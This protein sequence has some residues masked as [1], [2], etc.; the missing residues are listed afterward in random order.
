MAAVAAHGDEAALAA[1]G[2]IGSP[3]DSVAEEAALI[4]V[5]TV[6][7]G[8]GETDCI[9]VRQG[10]DP[11]ELARAF[12]AKHTL[13]EGI[14]E[15]LA[16][17][18]CDNLEEAAE[19]ARNSA[20]GADQGGEAYLDDV[21]DSEYGSHFDGRSMART[22]SEDSAVFE[23]LYQQAVSLK[24]K[25]QATK[26]RYEVEREL[27]VTSTKQPMSWVSHE[28]MRERTSG[29]Y[30]NYGEMLYA[31]S[32]ESSLLRRQ[33]AE[34]QRAERYAAE[35]ASATFTPEITRMA[36]QMRARTDAAGVPAWQRLSQAATAKTAERHAALRRER[37]QAEARECTFR[38]AI[39][40]RS[41]RLMA[42]RSETLKALNVSAHH[43]LYQDSLRRQAKQESYANWYPEDA[44]FQPKLVATLKRSKSGGASS[45]QQMV[46]RL[47]SS[48]EK[49]QNKLTEA[50]AK[51]HGSIDPATGRT[52]FKPKTGRGP[53]F[54]RRAPEQPVG[55]YLF[56][57]QHERDEKARARLEDEARRAVED[58][59]RLKT[60]ASSAAIVRRLTRKRFQQIFD[61]LD[62]AS[63]GAIDLAAVLE[64]APDT[65]AELDDDVRDDVENAARL[66]ER[67]VI[68][69]RPREPLGATARSTP[70]PSPRQLLVDA[71]Q[72]DFAAFCALMDEAIAQHPR[73]RPYLARCCA[74]KLP[75]PD[76]FQPRIDERS[77]ALAA[78]LRP[79]DTP[80]HEVLYREATTFAT[81]KAALKAAA[82]DETMR[83]CTFAPRLVAEQL[84]PTGR[85]MREVRE[86]SLYSRA[87]ST[88]GPLSAE[89]SR[90]SLR[91]PSPSSSP[92][93]AP[94]A[95]RPRAA[96]PQPAAA[97]PQPGAAAE[98]SGART[99]LGAEDS[100]FLELEA[101]VEA[102]LE[103]TEV[104]AAAVGRVTSEEDQAYLDKI[105][106]LTQEA[107]DA[108]QPAISALPGWQARAVRT[109]G[110][111][112]ET[113]A[114]E[115]TCAAE[116]S[117]LRPLTAPLVGGA[118]SS[119]GAAA[120]SLFSLP[121]SPVKAGAGDLPDMISLLDSVPA[122]AV[123]A[124]L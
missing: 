111:V 98:Q 37:E 102:M 31:E 71:S 124:A 42:D 116:P 65:L 69:P 107:V 79:K 4:L 78:K 43:Q 12:V 113:G 25:W 106:V 52:L 57:L 115:G 64:T 49:L 101:E 2:S 76:T 122:E 11:L 123:A 27:A 59:G 33:K 75:P 26:E 60:A 56:S 6:D 5:T 51:L 16:Q 97:A 48:Y 70:S 93:P 40:R 96:A 3:L 81:R 90:A 50:R 21:T 82:D 67:G 44:T 104:A 84:V 54:T 92:A 7:I 114:S 110:A 39:S 91:S 30:A 105:L 87:A 62:K 29:P 55:D 77:K 86:G 58:A 14:V 24:E 63:T 74:P 23:R 83:E 88:H 85:V 35:M 53:S 13:P 121:R 73:P 32:M 80:V 112:T 95:A 18:L 89:P 94:P 118:S 22:P 9:E 17:H 47:Y 109:G 108:M 46:D 120:K 61:Y 8:D 10:D 99:C 20:G 15:A 119:P 41:D 72:V 45:T 38:P 34:R 36:Q 28:M 66:A 117:A 68:S 19:S 100:E 103:A 1:A